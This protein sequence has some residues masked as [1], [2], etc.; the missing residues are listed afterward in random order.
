IEWV[1]DVQ[2]NGIHL[3]GGSTALRGLAPALRQATGLVVS[4]PENPAQ[5]TGL[6][7]QTILKSA[8][9]RRALFCD[10]AAPKDDYA[11]RN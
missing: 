9:L 1:D 4:L 2:E 8:P 11:P 7:L 6:G 10:A 5:C 3:T